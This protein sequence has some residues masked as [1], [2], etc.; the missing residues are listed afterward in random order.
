MTKQSAE[1]LDVQLTQYADDTRKWAIE[2][3]A[4][5]DSETGEIKGF[6]TIPEWR[7]YFGQSE[8]TFQ[9]VKQRMF[10]RAI[11]LAVKL[12][13]SGKG[14]HYI[15]LPGEQATS[16]AIAFN[17]IFSRSQTLKRHFESY[18]FSGDRQACIDMFNIK[19][20]H[21]VEALAQFF[22]G[23]DKIM[24]DAGEEIQLSFAQLLLK[25]DDSNDEQ[26]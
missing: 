1:D 15:G 25:K 7:E 24:L 17:Y 5:R 19:S 18:V 10:E 2:I 13:P 6:F 12:S 3:G 26:A 16:A 4:C 8:G 14:G 21:S 9:L 23:V 11:P 22:A 20:K